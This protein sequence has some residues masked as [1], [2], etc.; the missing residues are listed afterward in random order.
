MCKYSQSSHLRP[1]ALGILFMRTKGVS[2]IFLRMLGRILGA[3]VLRG[4]DGMETQLRR[5]IYINHDHS[6]IRKKA[7]SFMSK[8]APS[9]ESC[10]I[11]EMETCVTWLLL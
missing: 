4:E 6:Q 5:A 8:F 3:S 9:I 2:P 10:F 7:N 11:C 1:K